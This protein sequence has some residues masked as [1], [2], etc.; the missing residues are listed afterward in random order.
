MDKKELENFSVQIECLK[1]HTVALLDALNNLGNEVS[2]AKKAATD[3]MI[4]RTVDIGNGL[5]LKIHIAGIE[6]INVD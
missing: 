2:E 6:I 1:Q 4:T 3:K 5:I